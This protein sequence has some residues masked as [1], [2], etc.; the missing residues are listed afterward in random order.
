VGWAELRHDPDRLAI[1]LSKH[2][3]TPK[4]L[5]LDVQDVPKL[6]E[7]CKLLKAPA[8][9]ALALEWFGDKGHPQPVERTSWYGLGRTPDWGPLPPLEDEA[10]DLPAEPVERTPGAK[11]RWRRADLETIFVKQPG[12]SARELAASGDLVESIHHQRISEVRARG[13]IRVDENGRLELPAGTTGDGGWI[14]LPKRG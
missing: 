9:L 1:E 4:V 11:S 3:A 5:I 10:D 6:R 7:R 8:L 12:T 2:G 13:D 14:T